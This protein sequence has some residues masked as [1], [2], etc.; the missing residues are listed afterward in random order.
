MARKDKNDSLVYRH[1]LNL[2]YTKTWDNYTDILEINKILSRASKNGKQ[3]TGYPDLIYVNE[4]KKLLILAEIKPTISEHISK[5][6][7][8]SIEKYAVDGI[9]HYL[10]FFLSS[11]IKD[12]NLKTFFSNWKIIGIAIS[13]DINDDYNHRIT[14]FILTDKIEEQTNIYEILNENEYI[15]LFEN[16]DSERL[17]NEISV[18]SK[19]INRLLR[20]VDSQKRPILLSGLMICLFEVDGMHN[21]FKDGYNSWSSDMIVSN[22]QKTVEKILKKENIPKEKIDVLIEELSFLEFEQDLNN[23]ELNILR[24]ILDELKK[25]IIPLFKKKS[26]YDIIGKFYEEFLRY[27][28]ISNVKKGIV[29]TPQ[30]VTTLFTDLVDIKYNDVIL[31]ACCGTGS[32]LIAGMNKLIDIIDES[33]IPNKKDKIKKLKQTQLIGFEKNA[34]M[35]SL[36]ISNMLFRGDGKAQIFNYD[37]FSSAADKELENLKEKGICPTI[38]FINPPYGGKDN[39]DNPTKKEIQ[40]LTRMLDQVSRYG[41]IIAPL[42]TYFKDDEIRNNI[43]NKHT[44]K[45]VINMP[46]DLFMP[47]AATNTAIAVFETNKPQRRQKVIFYDLKDDG[48][49]L[50]KSK[51][52]T[53]RCNKW[54][55]IKEELLNALNNPINYDDN[56]TLVQKSLKQNDEWIIHAHS[57]TDYSKLTKNLFLDSIKENIIF[58]VKKEMNLLDRHIDE[59]TF[60]NILA[61][62]YTEDFWKVLK[63]NKSDNTQIDTSNWKYFKLD[64]E[65]FDIKRGVRLTKENRNDGTMPLVTAGFHNEGVSEYIDNEE[66]V[67][68]KDSYTIDMFGYCFYRNYEFNCDDNIIVLEPKFENN[69]YIAIFIK[70]IIGLDK[71]KYSYGR[72]YRLKHVKKHKIKLPVDER[73]K[74]DFKYMEEFIKKLPGA[75]FFLKD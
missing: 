30:H 60:L 61:D 54:P 29:L 11:N 13:G 50:S 59:I 41:I 5:E 72:Q 65:L 35:Y 32:F 39:K 68:Y 23:N 63:S 45:Y 58:N 34:T 40:F 21:D 69:K 36:A 56:L 6:G 31:D 9:K 12:Q 19:K 33:N 4:E 64:K 20:S 17:I 38:G 75:S 67:V 15:S 22:I 44:L 55:G 25:N 18:S 66:M 43:L 62:Y 42:S 70:T 14:N 3:N 26:N 52:R 46:S 74:P 27:A 2:K 73:G 49:V 8:Q 37:Y 53:D 1:V 71:I 7:K 24:N 47:N 28:G 48:F 10:S 51:G 16:V 57:D